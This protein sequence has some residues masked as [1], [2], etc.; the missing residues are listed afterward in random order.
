MSDPLASLANRVFER[1]A[2]AQQRLADHAGRVFCL[3]V[4][5][6]SSLLLITPAGQFESGT[7]GESPDLVLTLSPLTL[8]SLLADP[9]RWDQFVTARGDSALAGT[10]RD[11]AQTLP[12]FA[13]RTF[14]SFLGPVAGQRVADAGRRLLAFPEFAAGRFA[15]SVTRYARD[16]ARVV[17]AAAELERLAAESSALATRTDLLAARIDALAARLPSAQ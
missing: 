2:W 1:E 6:L 16:E 15:D 17:P 11:L 8:P 14:A 3:Q 9:Q 13:E 12:W 4:G 10:L 7:S 5:P